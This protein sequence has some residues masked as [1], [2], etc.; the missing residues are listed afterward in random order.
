MSYQYPASCCLIQLRI[1]GEN[2]LKM[3]NTSPEIITHWCS[4]T[5]DYLLFRT[6]RCKH[7]SIT[8]GREGTLR[9]RIENQSFSITIWNELTKKHNHAY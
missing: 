4:Q 7:R 2:S 3:P 5:M 1:A 8:I 9:E 6:S